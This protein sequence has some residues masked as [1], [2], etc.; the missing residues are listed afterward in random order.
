MARVT[1]LTYPVPDGLSED[2]RVALFW[3]YRNFRREASAELL[4]LANILQGLGV[5]HGEIPVWEFIE[6]VPDGLSKYPPDTPPSEAARRILYFNFWAAL[7]RFARHARSLVAS[8]TE[9]DRFGVMLELSMASMAV[10]E[11]RLIRSKSIGGV[12]VSELMRKSLAAS[13][14]ASKGGR[15]GGRSK[16]AQADQGRKL[17]GKQAIPSGAQLIQESALLVANGKDWRGTAAILARTYGCSA[18]YIRQRRNR[19]QK[20]E[21]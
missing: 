18:T 20:S 21:N 12:K 3:L 6:R 14:G 9:G 8:M 13:A 7:R 11:L 4:G 2:D 5:L 16:K 15:K 17:D 1:R 10:E 19:A